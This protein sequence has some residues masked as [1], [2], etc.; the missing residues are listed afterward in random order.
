MTTTARTICIKLHV[1]ASVL[2]SIW[3]GVQV[4]DVRINILLHVSF[5]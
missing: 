2:L 3:N 4:V 1:A 5:V